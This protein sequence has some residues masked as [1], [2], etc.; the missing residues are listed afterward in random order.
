MSGPVSTDLMIPRANFR[1]VLCE[2]NKM[3]MLQQW[4][5]YTLFCF[6]YVMG[7]VSKEKERLLL[8]DKMPGTFLLRFSESHLG[9]ITFTWVDH[10]ENGTWS[11]CLFMWIWH[12]W[13]WSLRFPVLCV[14]VCVW[15][16]FPTCSV[17]LNLS[18]CTAPEQG[19]LSCKSL[20]IGISKALDLFCPDRRACGVAF[21]LWLRTV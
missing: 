10:S 12:F 16:C 3:Q 6:R 2:W 8:K 17:D 18:C 7:F 9:G 4:S 1:C 19:T 21:L 11:Y 14:C 15:T 5:N 20:R 13:V